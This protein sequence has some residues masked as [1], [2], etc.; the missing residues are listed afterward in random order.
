MNCFF[1]SGLEYRPVSENK[2]SLCGIGSCIDEHIVVPECVDGATVV[3]VDSYAFIRKAKIKSITLPASVDYIGAEAFAWCVNLQSV[4][5]GGVVMIA[6]R[7]FMGCDSLTALDLGEKLETIGEKAFAYCP[8]L[9]SADLPESLYSL[10]VSAF[11]GCRALK[12][13]HL[14]KNLKVIENGTFYACTEL[15]KI[16]IPVTLEYI[17]EFAF[18][19]CSSLDLQGLPMRTI[20]NRYAFF[21]CHKLVS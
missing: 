1:S 8:K 6:E 16:N 9:I 3:S 2:L 4:T 21:E 20:I 10:G 5:L 11:D 15:K 12:Q 7:V 13:I 14:P 17:D 19:Y 18:A